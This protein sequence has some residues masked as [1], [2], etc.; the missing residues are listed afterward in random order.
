MLE[1]NSFSSYKLLNLIYY[2]SSFEVHCDSGCS[3]CISCFHLTIFRD[4][5]RKAYCVFLN[6]H[7]VSEAN[8]KRRSE[9]N[10][11]KTIFVF[12]LSITLFDNTVPVFHSP[13]IKQFAFCFQ[14]QKFGSFRS[15][16]TDN[17][18]FISKTLNEVWICYL[19]LKR[20]FR[21]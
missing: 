15:I 21:K 2:N 11:S 12:F 3:F 1:C 14:S 16:T 20:I 8:L 9:F 6:P 13:E 4:E 10:F 19:G 5:I 18:P 17:I 7:N